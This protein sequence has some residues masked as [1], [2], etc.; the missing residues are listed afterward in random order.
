MTEQNAEKIL[1]AMLKLTLDPT[2]AAALDALTDEMQ[3]VRPDFTREYAQAQA[4][5]IMEIE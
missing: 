3:E 1:D 4:R 5:K 2:D